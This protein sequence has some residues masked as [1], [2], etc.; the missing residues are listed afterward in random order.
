MGSMHTGLEE[1]RGGFKKLAAFYKARA[2]GGVGLIV[3]G[4]IS[5]NYTGKLA[6]FAKK[7]TTKKEARSHQI[8]TEAVHHE[9]AKIA[10]HTKSY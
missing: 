6:P 8:I 3:T 4:G 10:L 2:K 9:G 7:L 5:P 1:E